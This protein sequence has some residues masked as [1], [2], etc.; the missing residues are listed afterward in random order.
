MGVSFGFYLPVV[1]LD[2]VQVHGNEIYKAP[3]TAPRSTS[4]GPLK[5]GGA[6]AAVLQQVIF[7]FPPYALSELKPFLSKTTKPRVHNTNRMR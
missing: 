4:V 3:D 7:C 2:Q 6:D 5:R 1:S